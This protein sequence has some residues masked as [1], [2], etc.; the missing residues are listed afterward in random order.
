M[1]IL[2]TKLSHQR[3]ALEIVRT[4]GSRDAIEL[5]TRETMFHDFLHY[6][7]E[8][9]MPTQRGFWGLLAGGKTFADMNDRSGAALKKNAATLAVVE[10]TVGMMTGAMKSAVS[11][12]Q[13]VAGF[14]RYHEELAQEPPDWFTRRFVVDVRERMRR[15]Q[16]HWKATPYGESMEIVWTETEPG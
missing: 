2:L 13:V 5:V 15:L 16:G 14:R 6:A 4:D 7:V 12:D 3:H 8:A 10:G 11:D 9:S 1:R